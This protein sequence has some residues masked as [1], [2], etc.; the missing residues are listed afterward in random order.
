[1]VVV[2]LPGT[3]VAEERIRLLRCDGSKRQDFVWGAEGSQEDAGRRLHLR[4]SLSEPQ[5]DEKRKVDD[6][7]WTEKW[8]KVTTGTFCFT[9]TGEE[10]TLRK[11]GSLLHRPVKLMFTEC[12][13]GARSYNYQD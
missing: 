2:T 4:R 10:K 5:E 8:D 9:A 7:P 13:G 11:S 3:T 12:S 1:M 6:L